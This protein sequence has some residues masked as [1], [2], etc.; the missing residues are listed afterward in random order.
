MSLVREG[1]LGE[2]EGPQPIELETADEKALQRIPGIGVKRTAAIVEIR[3]E[4]EGIT[5]ERLVTV[6]SLG[7]DFWA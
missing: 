2:L 7:Q 5:M 6:S 3:E 1:E 4:D